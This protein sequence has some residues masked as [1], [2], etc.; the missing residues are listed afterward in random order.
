MKGILGF[1]NILGFNIVFA[2]FC[3]QRVE[4]VPLPQESARES[5]EPSCPSKV[6]GFQ[7]P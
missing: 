4:I 2:K 7:V 1:F 3:A 5:A 6:L